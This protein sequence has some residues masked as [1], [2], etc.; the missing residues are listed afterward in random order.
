MLERVEIL[1]IV[2]VESM[3]HHHGR[4]R[5]AA[6]VVLRCSTSHPLAALDEVVGGTL[7]LCNTVSAAV[8]KPHS[9]GQ[10]NRSQFSMFL[11]LV[12][13]FTRDNWLHVGLPSLSYA[14]SNWELNAVG[15]S[16]DA[17]AVPANHCLRCLAR[18]DK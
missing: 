18:T 14:P 2:G 4:H 8:S 17:E 13:L 16:L 1:T 11:V 5:L 6:A 10:P 3:A 12:H 15:S 9:P 7:N